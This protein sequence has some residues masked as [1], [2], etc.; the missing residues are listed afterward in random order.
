MRVYDQPTSRLA[1]LVLA[2]RAPE[3]DPLGLSLPSGTILQRVGTLT[4]GKGLKLFDDAGK[5]PLP[6]SLGYEHRT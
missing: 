2:A 6:E 5:V 4:G 3:F 1:W